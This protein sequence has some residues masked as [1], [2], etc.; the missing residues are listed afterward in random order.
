MKR[1]IFLTTCLALFAAF[2]IVINCSS[3]L[4]SSNLTPPIP[5]PGV[6]TIYITDTVITFDTIYLDDSVIV[7]DT[8]TI[9][10]TDTV[11]ISDTVI[12]YDTITVGTAGVVICTEISSKQHKIDWTFLSVPA[13][14]HLAFEAT[15]DRDK[16]TKALTIEVNGEM[17]YWDLTQFDNFDFDF[18]FTE[19]TTLIILPDP[20]NGFGNGVS[21]CLTLQPK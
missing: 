19:S 11:F 21:L 14:Y 2:Q 8:I 15:T 10:I 1:L 18:Q 12:V 20:P 3:P 6:D 7:V 13:E 17:F 16:P 5:N 9:V 4:D